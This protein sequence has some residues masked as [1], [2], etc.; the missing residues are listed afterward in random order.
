MVSRWMLTKSSWLFQVHSLR[1]FFRKAN[2][3][4]LSYNSKGFSQKILLQFLISYISERQMFVN[5]QKTSQLWEYK[6]QFLS[7]NDDPLRLS[8]TYHDVKPRRRC[9]NQ[10]VPFQKK[11][12]FTVFPWT[13]CTWGAPSNIGLATR[14][15]E[16]EARA[17]PMGACW[18]QLK[19][20]NLTHS[21][22]LFLLKCR[23]IFQTPEEYVNKKR[24]RIAAPRPQKFQGAVVGATLQVWPLSIACVFVEIWAIPPRS[25][26]GGQALDGDM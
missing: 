8:T 19:L 26:S 6:S 9:N 23:S 13:R 11:W 25:A 21:C 7:V 16:R 22:L 18:S 17:S 12:F 14:R 3:F 15:G 2:T 10:Q 1:E 20:V 24:T 5:L 4:T